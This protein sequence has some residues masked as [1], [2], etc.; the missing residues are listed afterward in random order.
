MHAI[1][2]YY[3]SG[4]AAAITSSAQV[5]RVRDEVVVLVH[6]L[7]MPLHNMKSVI[8]C[9][10]E[11]RYMRSD[12]A[13]DSVEIVHSTLELEQNKTEQIPVGFSLSSESLFFVRAIL[14]YAIA[15]AASSPPLFAI[16][17]A[18]IHIV[19]SDDN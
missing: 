14:E 9:R 18:S 10:C 13:L 16:F 1:D 5:N 2:D 3:D 12:H 8:R 11:Q 7:Q 4:S 15:A 17:I 6:T 19:N